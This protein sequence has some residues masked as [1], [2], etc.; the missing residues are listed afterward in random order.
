MIQRSE[1]LLQET[2]KKQARKLR[3]N[4]KKRELRTQR[5][6]NRPTPTNI[7]VSN[8]HESKPDE[9][10]YLSGIEPNTIS[11]TLQEISQVELNDFENAMFALITDL[12]A[13]T[14]QAKYKTYIVGGWAYDKVRQEMLGIPPCPYN[15]ADFATEIPPDIL[16]KKFTAIPEVPGLFIAQI[17]NVKI[18]IM[19]HSDLS[20]L[21][22]DAKGRDFLTF[23]ID[24]FVKVSEP[25]GFGFTNLRLKRLIGVNPPADMF[26]EDPLVILRGIYQKS[27]RDLNINSVKQIINTDRYLLVPRIV[28]SNSPEDRL[29]TPRRFNLRITKLFT[30][31]LAS[32]SFQLLK[33]LKILEV[34]FPTIYQ[35]MQNNFEWLTTQMITTNNFIWPKIQIIYANFITCAVVSRVPEYELTY[36]PQQMQPSKLAN[37]IQYI[38]NDSL[39]FSDAFMSPADLYFYIRRPLEEW[40]IYSGMMRR[41]QIENGTSFRM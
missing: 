39:L 5:K 11:S 36:L 37:I 10:D 4:E 9:P 15:D 14:D 19:Y 7:S 17:G 27:K 13:E 25:T 41:P 28:N 33:N 32:E 18:D 2:Q 3:E 6:L 8:T 1:K 20:N 22:R 24:R 12:L 23:Y 40:K 21:L 35:D 16:A 29:C 31:K 34:L 30:Q 26:K 38:W